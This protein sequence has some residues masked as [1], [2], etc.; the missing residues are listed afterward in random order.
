MNNFNQP[1]PPYQQPLYPQTPPPVR[2]APQ[3]IDPVAFARMKEKKA[4]R[5]QSNGIGFFVLSY[6]LTMTLI[7]TV[8]SIIYNSFGMDPTT[9]VTGY[10]L[11][12][13]AS[14]GAVLIPGIIYLAAS[15]YNISSGFGKTFVSPT[16]LI[17]LVLLGMGVAMISNFATDIFTSNIGLF[18]LENHLQMFEANKL[19]VPEILLYV[20]VVSFV[21][22]FA[23]EFAFRG[24][25]MGAM[26]KHGDAFAI[27]VSS[28]IF[29][30]MHGNTTQI[31][32]AFIVGLAFA[33]ADS[34]A[35]SIVPSLLIHFL[36]NFYAVVIDVLQT[37]ADL[38]D[39]TLY[40]INISVVL[41]FC[42]GGFLSFL[43]LAK[44][45]GNIFRIS[46]KNPK[47]SAS[48]HLSLKEKLQAFFINP[49]IIISLSLFTL[50]MVLYLL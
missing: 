37:N 15:G 19:S 24:I 6:A 11:D 3:P 36:N 8:L 1:Y 39:S 33:F 7:A 41:L 34:V 28:I 9:T 42:V 10:L 26:R 48:Q 49:G 20:F 45:R 44:T 40:I 43:Y 47:S 29:G 27:L 18:G 23:E 16:L 50:E 4:L 25:V 31:V 13:F 46:D 22:A 30:A 12:I 35:N 38:E 17:P 21:P 32:F 2:P 5:R 14:V